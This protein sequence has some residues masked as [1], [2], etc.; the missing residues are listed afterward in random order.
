MNYQEYEEFFGTPP[1]MPDAPYSKFLPYYLR[2]LQ[3]PEDIPLLA[4]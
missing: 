3:D 1:K 4:L 2:P